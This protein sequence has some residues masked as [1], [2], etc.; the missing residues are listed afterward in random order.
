MSNEYAVQQA[1][2][3]FDATINKKI[4]KLEVRRY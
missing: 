3:L 2:N 1:F 4:S